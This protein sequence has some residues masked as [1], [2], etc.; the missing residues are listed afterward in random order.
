MPSHRLFY[1]NRKYFDFVKRARA[2]GI[3]I[4]IVPGI[5]PFAKCSQITMASKTFHCDMPQEPCR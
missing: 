3:T 5:K 4:P 2:M 1:D